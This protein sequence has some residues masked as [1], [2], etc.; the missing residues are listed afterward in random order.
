M[1]L[2]LMAALARATGTDSAF[3]HIY[4]QM[5]RYHST[6]DIYS[7]ADAGGNHYVPSEWMNGHAVELDPFWSPGLDTI[8]TCIRCRYIAANAEWAGVGWVDAEGYDLIGADTCWFWAR[9]EQGGERVEFGVGGFPRDSIHV[10]IVV[11]LSD[12]WHRFAIPLTGGRPRNLHRAFYW[13]ATRTSNPQGCLFYLDNIQ[14]NLPRLDSLRFILTYGPRYYPHDRTW[15]LNQA[16]TY[17]N[18]L[19]MISLLNRGTG[20]DMERA[21]KLGDAFARCQDADRLFTDGRLRNAYM[22][23]DI[24]SRTTGKARLPGW[25]DPDSQRWF[26]DPY[27]T[28]TYTGDMAWL[29]IAW[30]TYDLLTSTSRYLEN[31][32]R[33]GT[34]IHDSCW[35]PTVQGYRGGYEGP[36]TSP[37][38]MNWF[39]TE[40][41]IDLYAA[42]TLLYRETNDTSWLSRAEKALSFVRRMWDSS[43]HYFRCGM[44][45][46]VRFD[47]LPVLDAQ[48]W[49]L[50]ATTDTGYAA[51]IA[52]AERLCSRAASG[53]RGFCFSA[54]GDGIWWEG[55][56]QMCC[57]YLLLDRIA[58]YD[59]FA[60]ELR[61]C[62]QS[63]LHGNQL[64]ITS[65]L[66]ESS[67][68]GIIRYWGKWY[69]YARLDIAATS[70][71]IFS[72]MRRNPFW[73]SPP[74]GIRQFERS[75]VNPPVRHPPTLRRG[76]LVPAAH[77]DI[78]VYDATGRRAARL[79]QGTNHIGRLASG[80]YFL[81]DRTPAHAGSLQTAAR[82]VVP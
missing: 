47:T 75:T 52:T 53:H 16:Y 21:Q 42:F 2:C 11:T 39:S 45:D 76:S 43:H 79:L 60:T 58:K 29:M 56:A 74:G 27:Q 50:L 54:Y 38:R 37:R 36:D 35:S 78:L 14:F 5:D 4:N 77:G 44:K 46:S 30:S 1:N 19:A 51:A 68:T 18:A 55:T 72:E 22:T 41:H 49:G 73:P 66:P 71:F 34:W 67:Y 59:T 32:Q 57:A 80:V 65:C 33:L 63:G 7:D 26:E 81:L 9:G 6:F 64:G 24:I 23:G 20:E 82:L 40:H 28:G 48:T 70:W 61:W 31:A 13:I 10:R 15:A 3:K 12:Q 69:Y 62:Q 8:M 25:W 17:S